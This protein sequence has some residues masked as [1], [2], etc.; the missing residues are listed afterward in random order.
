[1]T[2]DIAVSRKLILKLFRDRQHHS[3]GDLRLVVKTILA[4]KEA[5]LKISRQF[6]TPCYI[7][8]EQAL[9][10]S[11]I[12]FAKSFRKIP[13]CSFF[14]AMKA[15]AY[16]AI[17]QAV[18]KNDFGID[19]SSTDELQTVLR[20]G[21]KRILFSGPGKTKTDLE[22]ALEHADSLIINIDSFS[23]LKKL[24]A[25]TKAKKQSIRAGVR[26]ITRHHEA[27]SKFGIPLEKLADFWKEARHYPNIN[28]SGIQFHLSWNRDPKLYDAVISEVAKHLR[29][30]FTPAMRM[31]LK[32][33][34][35][36]GGF[37]PNNT[38]GYYPWTDYYPGMSPIG[39]FIKKTH[40]FFNR[41]YN[42]RA[43]YYITKT[44]SVETYASKICAALQKHIEPLGDFEYY[45][46]PGRII[47]NN[48]MH[49]LL[50]AVDV[51]RPGHVILDGGVNMVGW[52]YGE[53]FYF[54]IV[55]LSRPSLSEIPCT[56][57]G[58]LCTPHDIWGYYC[59]AKT[60]QEDDVLVV[61]NQGAYR[62]CLAQNWIRRIPEV[63]KIS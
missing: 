59:Y 63:Y 12:D 58:S 38:E 43:P 11:I 7:F 6:K 4:K 31:K 56:L 34:D 46:E 19:V 29:D 57:Y 24:G 18:L 41:P 10:A 13:R 53:H 62:Y 3:L 60:I 15:N 50:H 9:L 42:F 47:C 23:E 22:A 17:L 32:F 44:V 30:D 37:F 55:N 51:K 36:G 33:I 54:P 27:W 14:Y 40:N 35:F 2:N 8:D 20:C 28:L 61:P 45:V 21:A 49:I 52:E 48:S 16:P 1:M 39:S 5:M 26:I 25:L